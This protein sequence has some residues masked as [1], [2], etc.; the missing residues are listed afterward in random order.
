MDANPAAITAATV[1]VIP[2]GATAGAGTM[3]DDAIPG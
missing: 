3:F 2:I 1:A